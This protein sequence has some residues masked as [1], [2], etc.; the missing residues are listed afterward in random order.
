VGWVFVIAAVALIAGGLAAVES[1]VRGRVATRLRVGV[2]LSSIGCSAMAGAAGDARVNSLG[3]TYVS[4]DLDSGLLLATGASTVIAA[5]AVL[6][7]IRS[8]RG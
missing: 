3:G 5:L 7:L 6:R 8:P 2:A 1:R 4:V